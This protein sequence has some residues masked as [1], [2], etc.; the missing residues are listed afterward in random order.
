VA[1]GRFDGYFEYGLSPWDVAAGA[2]LVQ[3]AGGKTSDY[4]GTSN[5]LFG[6]EMLA[7]TPA[8]FNELLP[9]LKGAMH[10]NK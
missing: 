4:N 2:F 10:T 9:I 7:A 5:F 3:Q 6:K 8:V 1:A